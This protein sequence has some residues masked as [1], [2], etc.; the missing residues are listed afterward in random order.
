[1]RKLGH[2]ASLKGKSLVAVSRDIADGYITVNPLFLKPIDEATLR[3]LYHQLIKVQIEIKAEKFPSNDILAIRERNLRLQRL[4][5][6][7]IVIKSFA[8]EKGLDK[9]F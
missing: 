9:L 3:S 4:H 2:M 7:I 1:M 5:H 8:K 6:A